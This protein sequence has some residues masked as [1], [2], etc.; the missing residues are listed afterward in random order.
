MHALA[1]N[2]SIE[3]GKGEEALQE[4]RSNV[5]PRIKQAPGLVAA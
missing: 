1:V 4:L 5:V 2:V 3:A